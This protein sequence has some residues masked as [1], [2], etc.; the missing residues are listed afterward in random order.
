M[1][2]T[3][4]IIIFFFS[5]L[6]ILGCFPQE[7]NVCVS[8]NFFFVFYIWGGKKKRQ[9]ESSSQCLNIHTKGWKQRRKR[10][11]PHCHSSLGSGFAVLFVPVH[12][13]Q[14]VKFKAE[15]IRWLY[16]YWNI[17]MNPGIAFNGYYWVM[18]QMLSS[19]MTMAPVLLCMVPFIF[20]SAPWA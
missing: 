4:Y 1:F 17:C 3:G 19:R 14:C 18:T 5:S 6:K 11:S 7:C 9:A 12:E 10:A 2:Y 15:N 8:I 13:L 16:D 20:Q